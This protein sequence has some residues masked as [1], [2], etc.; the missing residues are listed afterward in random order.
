MSAP[1]LPFSEYAPT[2]ATIKSG[3]AEP[4]GDG[5][6]NALQHLA[7]PQDSFSALAA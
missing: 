6:A 2:V 7:S 1:M 3:F 5:K 4:P